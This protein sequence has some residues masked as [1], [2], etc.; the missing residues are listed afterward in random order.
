MKIKIKFNRNFRRS[1]QFFLSL[2]LPLLSLV[3]F[4]SFSLFR[5]LPPLLSCNGKFSVARRSSHSPS[6]D[7]FLSPFFLLTRRDR[8]VV[9]F[10]RSRVK[11]YSKLT[12]FGNL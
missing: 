7:L 5:V 9:D 2:S 8:E 6:S 10:T 12:N 3:F 4:L 1:H 11:N